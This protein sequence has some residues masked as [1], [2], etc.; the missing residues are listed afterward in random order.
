MFNIRNYVNKLLY[1]L[2]ITFSCKPP[3]EEKKPPE[4]VSTKPKVSR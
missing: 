3:I 1:I 2:R 4:P